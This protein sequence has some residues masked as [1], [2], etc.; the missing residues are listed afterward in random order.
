MGNP[1]KILLENGTELEVQAT[2]NAS[3]NNWKL[4]NCMSPFN[5]N[6]ETSIKHLNHTG[7]RPNLA[8]YVISPIHAFRR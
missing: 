5:N 4:H 1:F 2:L 8:K 6:Q 7:R 3:L